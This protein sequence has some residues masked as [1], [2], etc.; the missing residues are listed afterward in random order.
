MSALPKQVQAQIDKA[1]QL[2]DTLYK[3]GK[4]VLPA[5]GSAPAPDAQAPATA[6]ASPDPSAAAPPATPAPPAAPPAAT[7]LPQEG[8]E[9]KYKVLQGKYNAEVPRLQNTVRELTGAVSQLREQLTA[10]QTL[11][12]SFGNQPPAAAAGASPPAAP[13]ASANIIKDEEVRE[14]GADL[15]DVM[16]RVARQE[17]ASLVPEIERRVAP[18]AQRVD[19]VANAAGQVA[20]RVQQTDRQ[21]VHDLMTKEIPNW[22]KINESAAFVDWLDQKD[23]F[24]GLVRGDMLSQA[25]KANDGPRVLRF[26]QGFLSEHAALTPPAPA[27]ATPAPAA[28]AAPQVSLETLVTPG[29]PK[30]GAG[31]PD[32][33]GKRVWT[34]AEI[35]KFYADRSAGKFNSTDGKAR[36]AAMEADIFLAQRENRVKP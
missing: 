28:A 22:I 13:A 14:F 17:G 7:P 30:T 34:R 21:S 33:S 24:S 11:L 29:L 25:Y 19:Q 1:N 9:Q 35:S 16:R 27:A 3:D 26:F 2:V 8:F 18:V 36:A 20:Q 5:D 15:I 23:P 4:L 10:T 32:G 6:P 31:T 12:A